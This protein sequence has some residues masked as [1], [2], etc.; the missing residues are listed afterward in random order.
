M[1][2]VHG[3][4]AC[5]KETYANFILVNVGLLKALVGEVLLSTLVKVK[6]QLESLLVFEIFDA[7]VLEVLE[8][9]LVALGDGVGD[10][11][12]VLESGEPELG[13][14]LIW[15]SASCSTTVKHMH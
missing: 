6:H 3:K 11:N 14:A 10:A 12:V 5:R 9:L 15:V 8:Q 1:S 4:Q 13:N 2:S 7:E